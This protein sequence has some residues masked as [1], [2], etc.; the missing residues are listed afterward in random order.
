MSG[1]FPQAPDVDTFWDNLCQG[2]DC[3][4]EVPLSRWNWQNL[5]VRWGGFIDHVDQFDATFF[6]ISPREAELIDPQQRLFLQ[7][8]WKT[9]EDAGYTS[10]TLAALKTGLFVGVFNHDYAELLQKMR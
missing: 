7:T 5:T 3:I 9:I 4:S 2:K 8:V 10:S 6:N 1:V